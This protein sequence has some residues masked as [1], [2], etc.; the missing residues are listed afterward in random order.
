MTDTI[1]TTTENQET[2]ALTFMPAQEGEN[3]DF[4][5]GFS[6]P[7]SAH[8]VNNEHNINIPVIDTMTDYKWQLRGL[9]S[10]LKHPESYAKFE[11]VEESKRHLIQWLT[12]NEPEPKE[13]HLKAEFEKLIAELAI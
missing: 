1:S 8:A 4:G 2:I 3:T 7:V 10:H 9:Q 5:N 6:L 12:E 11:D 13:A